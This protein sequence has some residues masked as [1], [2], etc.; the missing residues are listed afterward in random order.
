MANNMDYSEDER[1]LKK[2]LDEIINS[3]AGLKNAIII[4]DT[5]ITIMSKT[6]F[7]KNDDISV[8]KIG[9]IIGAVFIAGEEQGKI[10]GYEKIKRQLTEYDEGMIFSVKAGKGILCI[11]TD[12]K[13]NIGFVRAVTKRWAPK[14]A[15][16]L[17][18][19]L[20]KGKNEPDNKELK[21]LMRSDTLSF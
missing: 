5:G 10:L 21:D 9:A 12:K 7:A 14:I 20:S 1:L 15:Q 8:E 3:T 18:R 16:I 17:N 2:I 11:A 19:Y 13:V 6:K 4:D